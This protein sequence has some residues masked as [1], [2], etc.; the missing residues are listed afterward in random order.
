MTL[1]AICLW[2]LPKTRKKKTM[3]ASRAKCSLCLAKEAYFDKAK[4]KYII[5]TGKRLAAE[6]KIRAAREVCK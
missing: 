3:R 4:R 1:C 5:E 6:A 2:P